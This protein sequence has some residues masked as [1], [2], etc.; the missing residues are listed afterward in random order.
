M[1]SRPLLVIGL[2]GADF[3]YLDEFSDA[4]PNIGA[5]RDDGLSEPLAS[6]HPPW[7]GSAWPSMYTGVDPDHHGVYDFFDYTDSYP[8]E[9]DV[10]TRKD[11]RAPAIWDYLTALGRRS[12]IVNVPV[13]HPADDLEG[14]LLP[15]YLAPADEDGY[16]P[17]IRDELSDALG[18]AYQIYSDHETGEP[19]SEKIDGYE[20][21]IGD[22][23]AAAAYLL[24]N[25]AW[26]FAFVQVQKTDTVFHHSSSTEDFRRM[27]EAAD[28]LVGRL[29]DACEPTANVIVCSDHGMG[30]VTGHNVYVNE[31]LRE[32]GYIETTADT[33][34]NSLVEVKGGNV[35]DSD[36][37]RAVE[38]L[39]NVGRRIGLTPAAMYR[40]AQRVGIAETVL[41]AVPESLVRSVTPG[42]DWRE[43]EAYCRRASEQ[44][45]RINL[46]GRDPAGVVSPDRYEQLRDEI[47]E[48]L[49]DLETTDG[50][51]IFE[52]VCRREEVYDG[53]Y[54]ERACDVLFRTN[55]MNHAISGKLY[56]R[57]MTPLDTYNHKSTGVF[58]AAGPDID[59]GWSGDGLS[60]VDVAPVV[61][62]LL[63][64]PVPER[65]TG[66]VPDG[67]TSTSVWRRS[68]GEVT[69]GDDGDYSQDQSEVTERLSDLGYLD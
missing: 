63:R 24:E 52:F 1:S 45:I 13:T 18:R 35:S 67:L 7:T 19:S 25:E 66:R 9:S 31:I 61:F 57:T 2:D 40:V 8:D 32:R 64:E 3:R 62:S 68:Y 58:L 27:Y 37:G 30:P 59:S 26:D 54:S 21:L 10:V 36:T 43:S 41:R 15:G 50:Q 28:E 20:S 22:R 53:P 34:A 47:V 33:T 5:L 39:V 12:V 56:G 46:R 42:V 14:V 38:R 51:P 49:S 6:I 55:D 11:V 60:L 65:M 4:L 69:V 29:V 44:G 23:G 16:P 17:G 48:L